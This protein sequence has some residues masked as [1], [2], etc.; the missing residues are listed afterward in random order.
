MI[1]RVVLD[2]VSKTFRGPRLGRNPRPT[3]PE[4]DLEIADGEFLVVVGPSG[5]GKSTMLRIIAGLEAPTSG[6]VYFDDRRVTALN[7]AERNLAFV[8]QNPALYPHM[9]IE[10]NIRFPLRMSRASAPEVKERVA[11]AASLL[12]LSDQLPK[13]P[14]QL[15]GGQR[16]RAAMG[17]AIVRD[18]DL[19]L[20]DEPLSNLDAML[21]VE[22][23]AEI[24]SLQRE[25]GRTTVY[26]T[27]DGEEAM[28][29]GHRVAVLRDGTLQQC[30]TPGDLYSTP[31]NAF[32]AGFVGNPQM[33]FVPG[34][35]WFDDVWQVAFGSVRLV[36]PGATVARHP[37]LAAHEGN[38]VIVGFRPE[39]ATL[40]PTASETEAMDV[41][42]T[43]V[44]QLGKETRV[45]FPAP[46][47]GI[48]AGEIPNLDL[49]THKVGRPG[50]L[51][52]TLSPPQ[53]LTYG[54]SVRVRVDP[55]SLHLFD[56]LGRAL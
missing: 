52:V 56:A 17:R 48:G 2:K 12:K 34:Q 9:T 1:V 40:D 39:T 49:V 13:R 14:W 18:P 6:D 46:R 24:S 8:F 50:E 41:E 22:M 31:A 43:G 16:Q 54:D 27:H 29:M 38:A 26:V 4:L 35:I 37:R 55:A 44:Q 20:L 5:C 10:E 23:R 11:A 3:I 30:G 15:S 47:H 7:P 45:L 19:F 28:T 42:V 32:V 21:R 33:N 36:L 25:L 51:T 53:P